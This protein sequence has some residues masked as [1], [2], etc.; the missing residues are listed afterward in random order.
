MCWGDIRKVPGQRAVV[1][2][3]LFTNPDTSHKAVTSMPLM[4]RAIAIGSTM[5][6]LRPFRVET[7]PP[8]AKP[9]GIQ[10]D[11]ERKPY[12]RYR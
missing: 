10:G 7:T 12:R 3:H 4:I 11:V 8:Q 6:V 1:N 9:C 5:V 2:E